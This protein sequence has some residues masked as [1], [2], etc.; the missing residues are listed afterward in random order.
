MEREVATEVVSF[1]S[2]FLCGFGNKYS[3]KNMTRNLILLQVLGTWL[4]F[5]SGKFSH[6]SLNIRGPATWR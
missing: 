1:G 5:M 4:P 6:L 3:L 2:S